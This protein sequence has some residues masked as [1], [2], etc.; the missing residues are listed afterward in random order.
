M[1]SFLFTRYIFP[2]LFLIVSISSCSKKDSP[3]VSTTPPVVVLDSSKSISSFDFK[4]G[5]NTIELITDIKGT[6]GTDTIN[7]VVPAE[8]D[9]SSLNPDIVFSGKNVSPGSGVRQDFTVPVR[10]IVRAA[11]YTTKSYV[12]TVSFRNTLFI[13]TNG[14]VLHA[15]DALTG[16]PIW[17]LANGKF[18]SSSPTITGGII[19]ICGTDGLYALD[20][21]NGAIKWQLNVPP[22]DL[23]LQFLPAPVVRDGVVYIGLSDGFVYA[24]DAANG[25]V[26]WKTAS[27]TGQAFSSSPVINNNALY[28]G[29]F[30]SL[31]YSINILNG[32]INWKFASGDVVYPNPL[33]VNNVIYITQRLSQMYAL[34]EDETVLWTRNL[35][36]ESSPTFFNG[37]VY[38]GG[39]TEVFG[40]NTVDGSTQWDIFTPSPGGASYNEKSSPAVVNNIAYAGSGNGTFYAYDITNKAI[41]WTTHTNGVIYSSPVVVGAIVYVGGFDQNVYAFDA[42]TGAVKWQYQTLAAISGSA[43]I[44]DE[45]NAAHYSSISGMQN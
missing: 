17:Q 36:L 14:G 31:V 20:A 2:V 3:P 4:Q 28:I 35:S 32:L 29:S 45:K 13:T 24:L 16:Q 23:G 44:V 26:K 30:D 43:C 41:L 15:L 11:D 38:C 10:Y 18:S 12:V 42:A 33:V 21:R 27:S 9:I 1:K 8:T 5:N 25:S 6:V 37:R 7:I 34:K 39:G 19:Y 22:V 40:L